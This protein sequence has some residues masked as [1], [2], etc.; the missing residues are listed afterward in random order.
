[1]DAGYFGG[2]RTERMRRAQVQDKW[3]DAYAPIRHLDPFLVLTA[4][5]L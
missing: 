3:M 2:D 5:A 1:M 4:L